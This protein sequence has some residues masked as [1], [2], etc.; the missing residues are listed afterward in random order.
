MNTVYAFPYGQY[1][2][3]FTRGP[4]LPSSVESAFSAEVA[5][6]VLNLQN[7]LF[8]IESL[9]VNSPVSFI[10]PNS[11]NSIHNSIYCNAIGEE[12]SFEEQNNSLFKN[13]GVMNSSVN[14]KSET[15]SES[16]NENV[17]LKYLL[18]F[19]CCR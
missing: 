11:N 4:W 7:E 9:C 5:K 3:L 15:S 13:A 19:F 8:K 10:R 17:F 16:Q 2:E 1:G 18:G 12:K 14:S 6:D